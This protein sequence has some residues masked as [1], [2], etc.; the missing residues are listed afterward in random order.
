MARTSANSGAL[1]VE[2]LD[3]ECAWAGE[4]V[5]NRA[6]IVLLHEGLGSLAMWKDF[7]VRLSEATGRAVF[8]WSRQGYGASSPLPQPREP[9]YMHR[10]AVVLE[11]VLR[12]AGIAR[13]ILFGH[14]DGASI[15]LL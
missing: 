9:D 7:P 1:N 10:E 14:S 13:P 2:G 12:A 11:A 5:P 8:A 4:R 3:L 6:E 15:A